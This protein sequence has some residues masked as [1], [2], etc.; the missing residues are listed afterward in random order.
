MI[1][2]TTQN[3]FVEW[4]IAIDT[5]FE[6]PFN[7]VEIEAVVTTPDGQDLA[8][9]AFWTGGHTWG[10][11]YASP[12]AGE[13]R[14]EAR[15]SNGADVALLRGASGCIHIS[16]YTGDNPLLR[17]GP[18][19]VASSGRT[20][21]H[22]DGTPFLW[23]A[24]TW[25]M[26]LCQRLRWPDEFREL[27]DLRRQQNFNVVQIVAGLYPDM[28]WRDPR[29]A[30]EAGYPW[31]ENFERINPAYFDQADQRLLHLVNSGL[32]PCLVGCWGY[33]L[34]L[35]GEAKM[36]QHWRYLIARYGALPVTWCAAG[37]VKMPFY[38]DADKDNTTLSQREAWTVMLRYIQET[39]PFDRPLTAHPGGGSATHR[40]IADDATYDFSMLQAG[41]GDQNREKSIELV[42]EAVSQP[43]TMPVINAEVGYEALGSGNHR[44]Y[45]VYFFWASIL[46][47]AAGHSY[48]AN[49]IWQ[50]NRPGEP[51]G[52]SP[53][54]SSWGGLPWNEAA[55]LPGA[56]CLGHS[57]KFLES[58][59]WWR[60]Q[61]QPDWVTP[62]ASP[63]DALAPLAGGIPGELH[64]LFLPL[65]PN[66]RWNFEIRQLDP[67]VHR[68]ALAF[69]PYTGDTLEFDPPDIQNG[70]WTISARRLPI[71]QDWIVAID[72]GSGS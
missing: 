68:R 40:E 25:W 19:R 12:L 61:P 20:F 13:H 18:I 2:H 69:D 29:G 53:H 17:H 51:Y 62:H 67:A 6:D 56:R 64:L 10:V 49:G 54:G 35:M 15:A 63:E 37:E 48:G 45:Q 7:E 31:E 57:K 21:E 9:P 58:F 4:Q 34:G 39:D 41:H 33:F 1:L 22:A 38:L 26:G 5:Q 28:D 44:E 36:K 3:Q 66:R 24:D 70:A 27:T 16:G 42:R 52:A 32:S 46:S 47:G 43:R 30:N 8:V 71:V 23:L 65:P 59:Q 11:R 55:H 14:W 50:V 60:L 72:K